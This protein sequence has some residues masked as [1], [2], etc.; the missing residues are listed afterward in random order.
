MKTS[1]I[2]AGLLIMVSQASFANQ[3]ST[4]PGTNKHP[5][6]TAITT[7]LKL[8][9]SQ[10]QQLTEIMQRHQQAVKQLRQSKQ[11]ARKDMHSLRGQHRE[12]LL[13]ILDHQQLY[14]LENYMHQFRPRGK[15]QKKN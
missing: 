3:P 7:Q 11:Q 13:T 1:I 9:E 15:F 8:N 5:D 6:L 12:Q 4:Q 14:E 2:I 10:A